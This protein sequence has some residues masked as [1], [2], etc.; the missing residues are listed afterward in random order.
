M[1]KKVIQPWVMEALVDWLLASLI[2]KLPLT[3]QLG[4]MVSDMTTV[5]S[6]NKLLMDT[7]LRTLIIGY[8]GATLGKFAD[9]MLPIPYASTAMLRNTTMVELK[10]PIGKVA[11]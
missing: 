7:K 3:S 10:E 6:N 1:R 11:K 2:H 9:K 5:S 8:L 4:D